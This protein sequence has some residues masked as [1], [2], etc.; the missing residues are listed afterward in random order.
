MQFVEF[1]SMDACDTTIPSEG[2]REVGTQ[3]GLNTRVTRGK[4]QVFISGW[5]EESVARSYLKVLYESLSR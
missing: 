4:A 3:E 1:F 2:R 5:D